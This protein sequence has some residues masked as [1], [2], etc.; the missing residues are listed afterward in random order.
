[1]GRA[2]GGLR[3]L[4]IRNSAPVASVVAVAVAWEILGRSLY[5]MGLPALSTVLAATWRLGVQGDLIVLGDSLRHLAIGVGMALIAGLATG[6]LL[7]ISKR[8]ELLLLPYINAAMALPMVAFVPIFILVFGFRSGPRI[9]TIVAFSYFVVVINTFAGARAVDPELLEMAESMG[10]SRL[11]TFIS[12][13]VP[14][15]LPLV[16][17][18]IALGIGR[19]IIGMVTGEYLVATAGIGGLLLTLAQ[20]YRLPE[21]YGGVLVVMVLAVVVY[22]ALC[23]V[24]AR[25]TSWS[26]GSAR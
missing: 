18:G 17:Q 6:A 12:I 11:R 15:S 7:V 2:A 25:I 10:S 5:L 20:N 1:M 8:L 3:G 21:L 23:R 13:R 26:M 9:A 16:M 19:G 24:E 22:L 14:A 4:V